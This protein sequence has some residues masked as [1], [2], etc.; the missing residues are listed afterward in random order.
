MNRYYK[1][2]LFIVI[3][4]IV[5]YWLYSTF[6]Q[7]YLFDISFQSLIPF[8]LSILIAELLYEGYFLPLHWC[9]IATI[10]LV[11]GLGFFMYIVQHFAFHGTFVLQDVLSMVIHVVLGTGVHFLRAHFFMKK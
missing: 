2:S 9:C 1:Y 10:L 8:F 5:S 4:V 3:A 7:W 6:S 11:S